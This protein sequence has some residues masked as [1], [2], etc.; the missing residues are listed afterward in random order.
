MPLYFPSNDDTQKSLG[1]MIDSQQMLV[2]N[3]NSAEVKVAATSKNPY[4][5]K[6]DDMIG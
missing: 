2:A 5:E 1:H 6:L 3:A 4:E